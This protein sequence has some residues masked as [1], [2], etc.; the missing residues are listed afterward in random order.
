MERKLQREKGLSRHDLGRE[1]FVEEV[2]KWK[3]EKGDRIYHQLRK[4]GSSYD[5][6]RACFTMGEVWRVISKCNTL[7]SYRI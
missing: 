1:R 7:V 3:E 2:W 4:F 6:D 5:W